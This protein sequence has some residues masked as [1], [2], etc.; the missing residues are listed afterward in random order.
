MKQSPADIS[1]NPALLWLMA[2]AC[3]LCAGVNYYSQPLIASL[4]QHFQVAES[5]IAYTVTFAQL[6]YA[7]GLLLIVP[8]GD[9]LNK[10]RLIPI[11]MNLT[12]CGLLLCAFAI[13]LPML[14]LGTIMAGLFSVAAQVL[15]PLAAMS[16]VPEKTGEVV[17]RLMTGLL[18]GILCSTSLAGFLSHL[19]HWNVIYILSAILLLILSWILKSK[20]PT[21][22]QHR[23]RY[24]AV[25]YSMWQLLGQHPRLIY[26]A[27]IGAAVF[28]SMSIL[29]STIALLMHQSFQLSDVHIGLITLVGVFGALSTQ[30]IGKFADRGYTQTISWIGLAMMLLS[31]G[32]LYT[33]QWLLWCYVL[34]FGFINLGLAAIHTSN[35]NIIFRL[36][37][38]A[39]SRINSIYMTSYFIGGAAGS[40]SGAAAYHY[41]GWQMSCLVGV[42]L[43][44]FAALCCL[45]DQHLSQ[46]QTTDSIN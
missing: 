37:P 27:C 18:V 24:T 46:H 12:A 43:I 34:G 7:L 44:A 15:I 8:L 13:N 6:S 45:L 40:A 14:W 22:M 19:F 5:Q 31:W 35:Q 36:E 17:G 21:S 25:L 20:L 1:Q 23:H 32:F 11:L 26:R 42:G 2:V 28:A 38:H 3:G 4:Q 29:F 10:R 41:G 33:G 39:K 30:Y 9:I 16:T